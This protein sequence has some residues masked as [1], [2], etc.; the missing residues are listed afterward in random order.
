MLES[1]QSQFTIVSAVTKSKKEKKMKKR[2]DVVYCDP[3]WDYKGQTQHAGTKSSNT[4]GAKTHYGTLELKDL[5]KLNVPSICNDDCLIFMWTSSPHMDQAITLMKYWDFKYATIAFVWD[6]QAVNPGFYT[7]SQCE[8]V[9][10]GKSGKIPEN[11]GSRNERQFLSK[12]RTEH[13]EKPKEIKDRIHKMFPVHNKIEL[14]AREAN[15]KN[16]DHWGN[17]VGSHVSINFDWENPKYIIR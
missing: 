10:V 15:D 16:W 7:M 8:I 14:F 9:I 11:R 4:G 5:C 13:S 12:M 6:K 1:L 3:P 17:E 2:Y